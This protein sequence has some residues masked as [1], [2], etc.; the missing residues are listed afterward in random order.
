MI[1]SPMPNRRRD[2]SQFGRPAGGEAVRASGRETAKSG[3]H[4][5]NAYQLMASVTKEM[6]TYDPRDARAPARPSPMATR[7]MTRRTK[8]E[9]SEEPA[10][11][12]RGMWL[13]AVHPPPCPPL[14]AQ[15]EHRLL[16]VVHRRHAVTS[17]EQDPLREPAGQR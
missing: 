7:A 5:V 9:R 13:V 14:L 17:H 16:E 11:P 1:K 15:Q 2:P 3:A 6:A 8:S 4:R 10:Q 12:G